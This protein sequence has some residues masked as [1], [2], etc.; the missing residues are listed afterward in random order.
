MSKT[1]TPGSFESPTTTV[2]VE[3]VVATSGLDI[4]LDLDALSADLHG[5][6]YRPDNFNG[7]IYRQQEPKSTSLIFRSGKVVCTGSDSSQSARQS[8][9]QVFERL[10]DLGI[11]TSSADPI[12]VVNVVCSSEI[13]QKL[14]LNA[15]A[16]GLGI[17][18]VEYEPEQ[19]PGAIYRIDSIGVAVLLFAS[20]K[21]VVV[22][23]S[24]FKEAQKGVDHMIQKLDEY[25]LYNQ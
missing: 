9:E 6:Q 19:F 13:D 16:I 15:V 10:S 18:N 5:A 3:N 11:D 12:E 24:E 23:A 14:N 4:E 21:V 1:D 25:G 22:G 17:E 7:V 8:I 20:G 2:S